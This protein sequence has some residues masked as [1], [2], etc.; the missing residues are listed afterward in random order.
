MG[1]SGSQALSPLGPRVQWDPLMAVTKKKN[2]IY[3]F[4]SSVFKHWKSQES[5]RNCNAEKLRF[6][7]GKLF[8]TLPKIFSIWKRQKCSERSGLP[9]SL[10]R[11]FSVSLQSTCLS[12]SCLLL[13]TVSLLK[14]L[15]VFF[16]C[17]PHMVYWRALKSLPRAFW[18]LH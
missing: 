1:C 18:C 8:F 7:C 12:P 11:P 4:S 3:V 9:C 15:F 6:W 2:P 5:Q 10:Q 16:R 14:A 17:L 13:P